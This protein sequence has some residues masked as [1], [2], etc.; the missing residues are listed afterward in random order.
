MVCGSRNSGAESPGAARLD[1]PGTMGAPPYVEY[2]E[3]EAICAEC[4]MVFRSEE[5][6]GSH[7]ELT[8]G[9]DPPPKT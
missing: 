7:K 9:S 6:L 5:A 3:V 4:G 2:D 1:R 8:H